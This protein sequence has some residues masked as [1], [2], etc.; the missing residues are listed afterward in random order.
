MFSVSSL[1][2]S[3]CSC[4]CVVSWITKHI[5]QQIVLLFA[6]VCELSGL[7]SH[8][9][10]TQ[11]R[12]LQLCMTMVTPE[13]VAM[14]WHDCNKASA[15]RD[16]RPQT[17]QLLRAYREVI[18]CGSELQS[19]PCWRPQ[20][21]HHLQV[22]S[23]S[24]LE[25]GWNVS[26]ETLRAA[27]SVS[28]R[29]R[30]LLA[31]AYKPCAHDLVGT[32]AFVAHLFVLLLPR[33]TVMKA[34]PQ[35]ARWRG[36]NLCSTRTPVDDTSRLCLCTRGWRPDTTFR[37]HAFDGPAPASTV[38]TTAPPSVHSGQARGLP[39]TLSH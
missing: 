12:S 5:K 35:S 25:A 27:L 11:L 23:S 39:P 18:K 21:V 37:I 8:G 3:R 19:T 17:P 33:S 31:Q 7:V 9:C 4:S 6:S 32:Y 26:T 38:L 20:Y 22:A 10:T 29:S 30:R 14:A 28:A 24:R 34:Q 15:V 16:L 13:M 36:C 1:M 2:A